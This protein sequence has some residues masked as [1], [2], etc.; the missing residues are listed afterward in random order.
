VDRPKDL[1]PMFKAPS[2][3]APAATGTPPSTGSTRMTAPAAAAAP[4]PA[5]VDEDDFG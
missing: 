5:P 4:A 1:V 3:A 2:S